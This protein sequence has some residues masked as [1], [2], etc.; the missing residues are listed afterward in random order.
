[1]SNAFA[2][3]LHQLADTLAAHLS[4]IPSEAWARSTSRNEDEVDAWT[5]QQTLAHL[6]S[7][8]NVYNHLLKAALH[9]KPLAF[10]GFSRRDQIDTFNAQGLTALADKTP[11]DLQ[12]QLRAALHSTADTA[13]ALTDAQH[14]ATVACFAYS[15]PLTVAQ[16]LALQI[17]HPALTHAGQISR[18]T[19][20]PFLWTRYEETFAARTLERYLTVTLPLMYHPERGRPAHLNFTV[21]KLGSWHVTTHHNGSTTSGLG[22]ISK[23]TH[24]TLWAQDTA[25]MYG[26]LTRDI[27][28]MTAIMTGKVRISGDIQLSGKSAVWFQG[29]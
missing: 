5:T 6:V 21:P 29:L 13:A 1:M 2:A 27:S 8:A 24:S 15:A 23:G 19:E 18:A 12:A 16:L 26:L 4:A 28:A 10:D 22:V 14:A 25:T 9:H 17:V 11:A 3:D 20:L 7:V